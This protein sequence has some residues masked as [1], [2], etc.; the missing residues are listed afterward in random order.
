MPLIGAGMDDIIGSYDK[1]IYVR[2]LP[3]AVYED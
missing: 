3:V 1:I 2:K